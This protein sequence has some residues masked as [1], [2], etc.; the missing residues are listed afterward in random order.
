MATTALAQPAPSQGRDSY[1]RRENYERRGG[2]DGDQTGPN[3][4]HHGGMFRE[5]HPW[6]FGGHDE[7]KAA[8][9]RFR[10][11]DTRIDIQCGDSESTSACVESASRLIDK[12]TSMP[13][14]TP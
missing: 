2:Y 6:M 13:P 3:D 5:H 12:V 11:G 10:R 1:D 7:T 9:F 14:T 8:R 4:M